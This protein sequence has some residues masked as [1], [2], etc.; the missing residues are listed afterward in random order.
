[1]NANLITRGALAS[2]LVTAIA[3]PAWAQT[4]N[5][6]GDSLNGLTD[7]QK[8]FPG[9]MR[10]L[11]DPAADNSGA[12]NSDPMFIADRLAILNQMTA[13]SYLIDEGRWDAWFK[14]FAPDALVEVTVPT[15]GT[16]I[17]KGE[18]FRE[19]TNLRY[20]VPAVG[21]TAQRRHTMGNVHVTE[22]TATTAKVR[23]YMFI[24][25][26]PK[27]DKLN[28]LTSGTY[29]ATMEKRNGKWLITRWYIQA[30]APL[31][32]SPIPQGVSADEMKLIPDPR[33]SAGA[34]KYEMTAG[35][36]PIGLA[37]EI[38][39]AK[40][41]TSMGNLY[42]AMGPNNP[43]VWKNVDMAIVDYLTPETAA[44]AML[45]AGAQ[46]VAIPDLPGQ[47]VVK[48]VFAKYGKGGTLGAYD[49]VVVGIP[50]IYAGQ[51]AMYVAFIYVTTDDA[52]AS[53]REL[54]GF[55]KKLANIRFETLGNEVVGIMER[56]GDEIVSFSFSK[57]GKLFSLPLP[58]NDQVKIGHPYNLTLP[59]PA[60]TGKPQPYLLPFLS[61]RVIPNIEVEQTRYAVQELNTS[62][63]EL[64][65][66][67]I[68]G[69]ANAAVA[70]RPSEK[71]PL[72]KL[73]VNYV[74]SGVYLEG[75][76]MQLS[77]VFPAQPI[78]K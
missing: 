47:A 49:E 76:E 74:L 78:S 66:G 31:N 71:D 24:S 35:G 22:Q 40:L 32:P 45:P 77:K 20:V 72:Y 68:F 1:M 25:T 54:G 43:W 58:A 39:N 62:L 56:G 64:V 63:W 29:N 11:V 34:R 52:M 7:A 4:R 18:G 55:P 42:P 26:V 57:G 14:L 6:G 2:L 3:A 50:C 38:T 15:L 41:G 44:A 27:A 30:D 19:F 33:L 70:L 59:V 48:L 5:Y 16:I 69:T 17:V 53:G 73:P 8:G 36:L 9:P 60:P 28:I 65:D 46:L 37:G 75:G 67:P 10:L 12:V 51:L 21:S 61:M 23:S 13:Y